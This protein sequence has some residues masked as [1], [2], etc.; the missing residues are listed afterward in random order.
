LQRNDASLYLAKVLIV[1]LIA[2]QVLQGAKAKRR[3]LQLCHRQV[4][5][6]L[7]LISFLELLASSKT[8]RLRATRIN[9]LLHYQLTLFHLSPLPTHVISPLPF[10][11][12]RYFT[13]PHCQL[14]LFHPSSS[15]T[16]RISPFF[17]ANSRYFTISNCQ[18]TSVHGCRSKS[19]FCGYHVKSQFKKVGASGHDLLWNIVQWNEHSRNSNCLVVL[20]A[21]A[22]RMELNKTVT[23]QQLI[24]TRNLPQQQHLSTGGCLLS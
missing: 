13:L 4:R 23:T 15:P 17:I 2:T 1:A 7:L 5:I 9:A 6:A 3:D 21:T 22:A 11:N 20:Q 12:S 16:H 10:A 8:C 19:Q 14:T 24:M 18:L